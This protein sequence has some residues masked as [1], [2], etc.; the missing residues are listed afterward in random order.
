MCFRPQVKK[1]RLTKAGLALLRRVVFRS[2]SM[3]AGHCAAVTDTGPT[4]LC[5]CVRK[6]AS[7]QADIRIWPG[8]VFTWGQ[9]RYGQLGHGDSLDKIVPQPVQGISGEIKIVS[10]G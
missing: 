4:T 9:G 10:A 7:A 5:V 2:L 8:L 6:L 3:G 1:H